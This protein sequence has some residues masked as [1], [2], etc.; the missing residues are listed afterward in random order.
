M[1]LFFQGF[2]DAE[3]GPRPFLRQLH[4]ILPLTVKGI[5]LVIVKKI[6]GRGIP[7]RHR[8]LRRHAATAIIQSTLIIGAEQAQRRQLLILKLTQ[9]RHV[10][11]LPQSHL[12][13]KLLELTFSIWAFFYC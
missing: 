6:D 8:P 4:I 2:Y 13:R 9:P 1:A 3:G 5:V 12:W 11:V 7:R 10:Q